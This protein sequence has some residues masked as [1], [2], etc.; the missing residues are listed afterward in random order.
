MSGNDAVVIIATKLSLGEFEGFWAEENAFFF[1]KLNPQGMGLFE[2]K[3]KRSDFHSDPCWGKRWRINCAAPKK[4][5]SIT[6]E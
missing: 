6:G 3:Q 4:R 5:F 1:E 2:T